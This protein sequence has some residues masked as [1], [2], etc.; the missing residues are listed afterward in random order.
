MRD[1]DAAGVDTDVDFVL[2]S[3]DSGGDEDLVEPIE[4]DYALL[5]RVRRPVGYLLVLGLVAYGVFELTTLRG[6]SNLDASTPTPTRVV[7]SVVEPSVSI[8]TLDLGPGINGLISDDGAAMACPPPHACLVAHDLPP[9]VLP[10]IQKVF[11]LAHLTSSTTVEIA[12]AN[13]SSRSLWFREVAAAA[14]RVTVDIRIKQLAVGDQVE[15]GQSN[16]GA[17]VLAYATRIVH[18]YSV[19]VLAHVPKDQTAP[20]KKLAALAADPTLLAPN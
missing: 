16:D 20:L 14:G 9:V 18:G 3:P 15:N 7:P 12:D 19:Q 8:E 4:R 1:D 11:P 2:T 6:S 13:E 5:H 17:G 10:R